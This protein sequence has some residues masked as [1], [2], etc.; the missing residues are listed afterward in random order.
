M[1]ANELQ[2]TT[3]PENQGQAVEVSFA[4]DGESQTIFRRT[5]DLGIPEG[6]RDI[7]EVADLCWISWWMDGTAKFEPWDHAP[8]VPEEDWRPAEVT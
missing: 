4:L 3:P 2:Y 7:Y 8:A 6:E 5:R 1:Y